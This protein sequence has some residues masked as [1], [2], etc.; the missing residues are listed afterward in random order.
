MA[1]ATYWKG[2]KLYKKGHVVMCF[3]SKRPDTLTYL[4]NNW[5]KMLSL[6]VTQ[7]FIAEKNIWLSLYRL[8]IKTE[9]RHSYSNW[10]AAC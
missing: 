5:S 7:S 3:V 9:I 10:T 4:G 6:G 2:Q 8:S 1:L